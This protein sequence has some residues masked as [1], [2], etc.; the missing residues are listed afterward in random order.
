VSLPK[1]ISSVRR[2]NGR[3]LTSGFFYKYPADA[4][5][6]IWRQ[7]G[8]AGLYKGFVPGLFGVSHGAVQFMAYE[9]LKHVL[10]QYKTEGQD[11]DQHV[12]GCQN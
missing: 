4:F 10:R 6:S 12:C 5:G 11:P 3:G 9:E 1:K 7:E 2:Y 8:L